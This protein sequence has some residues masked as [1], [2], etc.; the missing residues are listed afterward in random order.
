MK[1]PAYERYKDSGVEWL[2]MV[3]EHWIVKK[4]KFSFNF[5]NSKRIP[6]S[7]EERTGMQRIF[8]YYGAS[9][10]IDYV[11]DYLFDGP[12]VLVAEDGANLLSRSTPL[13]F[14]ADGKYWVNNHAHILLPNEGPFEYWANLLCS[15]NFD[16]YITGSAQ[17]KMTKEKIGS[18]PLPCPPLDEQR[19]I[20]D[21]LS[22]RIF[23]IDRLIEK[24]QALIE[25]LNEKRTALITRAVTKGL[26]ESVPMKDSGVG[27]LGEIPEG[28]K[29]LPLYARY[30]VEL[31][32]MLNESRTT[33]EDLVPYLRNVDVQWDSITFDDLPEINLPESEYER[34]TVR[35][36]DLLVCEGGE[37]GR[38]A[39]VGEM[40]SL[41]GYQKALH[42]LRP[43]NSNEDVR[44]LFYTLYWAAK[45]GVF[46]AGGIS[47]IA[48]LT[49]EQLRKYRF[50]TPPFP[51]QV[52]IATFLDRESAKLS[53]L[54]EIA[55]AAI[56]QLIEYRTALIT[57]AVTGK[58]DVRN[59]KPDR[60]DNPAREAA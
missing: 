11:D 40:P 44:Y 2:G 31:G 60:K 13:A 22:N 4:A 54:V 7:A 55:Q 50:P 12:S 59:F 14:I 24:K 23:Q 33:G 21:F 41:I 36:G 3:P 32:K 52:A 20:A 29:T 57:A 51:E 19:I 56:E 30:S 27:W 37:V 5:L 26:D 58:I 38:A 39:I 46:N 49:G 35:K 9:G 43:N 53:R 47:T 10:I 34:Y 17:P 1:Y 18:I 25:K 15:V 45:T 28:W 16:P 48:H 6:L 8:P 42:R